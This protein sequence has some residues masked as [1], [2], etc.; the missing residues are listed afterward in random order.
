MR[1]AVFHACDDDGT[2]VKKL[3]WFMRLLSP[4]QSD[5]ELQVLEPVVE[6][7]NLLFLI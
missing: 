5:L 2:R 6:I 7:Q 4:H 3:T 1:K